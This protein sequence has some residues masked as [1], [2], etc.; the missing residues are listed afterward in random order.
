[1]T[2]LLD[3]MELPVHI[4]NF[5]VVGIGASAGGL[6]AFKQLV[7]AIPE[8]SGMAYVFVQHVGDTGESV[9]PELL[10]KESKIPIHTITDKI[11]L[12]PDNIYITPENKEVTA[13]GSGTLVLT[14]SQ[15][16]NG[17]N[18]PIDRFFKSLADVHQSF[19]VGVV[20]S[21]NALDGTDGLKAIIENGGVTVAQNPGTA[22]FT[23]MPL[24]AIN[25]E[26]V[27]FILPAEKIPG[28][29]VKIK[30]SYMV[31][32]AGEKE[33]VPREDEAIYKNI[34]SLLLKRTGH[35]FSNYKQ[36][37]MR[38]RIARRMA[39]T[40]KNE[41]A[42]YLNFIKHNK[43]EQHALFNDL[44]IPVTHFFRD[45][46]TYRELIAGI[47]PLILK[48]KNPLD[49]IRVWVAGCATG[50]EAYS[51]AICLHE[52][53]ESRLPGSK[54]QIFASDISEHV[55]EKARN[56]IYSKQAVKEISHSR[57]SRYFVKNGNDY[58]VGKTI[59]EMCVFAVHNFLRNPPFSRM[60]MVSCRN[61]FIYMDT[62]FQKKALSVFHYALNADGILLLG[63]AE[64]TGAAPDLFT[65]MS[66][67]H[68][69][70]TRKNVSTGLLGISATREEKE[71]VPSNDLIVK[72]D[73]KDEPLKMAEKV[74][75]PKYTPPA[76]IVN[77]QMEI[78]HFLG[79]L[80]LILMPQQGK[81]SL[82]ILK[83]V[84]PEFVFELRKILQCAKKETSIVRSEKIMYM[85][86]EEQ[87]AFSVEIIPLQ[88]TADVH[89]LVIFNRAGID[90]PAERK[91]PPKTN[92]TTSETTAQLRIQK[93]ENELNQMRED[94]RAISDDQEIFSEELK[95]ANEELLSS[96]EELQSINEELET[97]KEELEAGNE[98][99]LVLN[100][101]LSEQHEQLLSART[102]AQAIVSSINEPIIILDR[103]F[104]IKNANAFFY[105]FFQ[106]NETSVEGKSF[107]DL[108]FGEWNNPELRA[109]LENVIAEKK[110]LKNYEMTVPISSHEQRVLLLS[111][112]QLINEPSGELLILLIFRDITDTR[113]AAQLR[114][115]EER[116]R[117]ASELT[118]LGTWELNLSTKRMV[119]S[120]KINEIMGVESSE[121]TM[122][123][124]LQAVHPQDIDRAREAFDSAVAKRH[125][126]FE[127][128]II[129]NNGTQRWIR[130]NGNLLPEQR[131][132]SSRLLGTVMDITDQ[133]KYLTELQE[134]ERLFK[135]IADAAPVLI[136][137]AG[138]DKRFYFFNKGWLDFTGKTIGQESGNGWMRGVHEEDREAITEN[139]DYSFQN[140]KEFFMEFRLKRQDGK[141]RWISMH[142]I[143]RLS[144]GQVFEGYIGGGVDITD[145]K[146]FAIT[147]SNQVQQRTKE[148]Q[149]SHELLK[150]KNKE[151]ERS[152]S[153]LAS[154]SYVASHDLQEPLRKIQTFSQR[155]LGNEKDNLSAVSRDYF[156]RMN[157]AA[158]E[159]QQLMDDIL[160]YSKVSYAPNKAEL[161]SLNTIMDNVISGLNNM[162]EEKN[163][164]IEVGALP[165]LKVIQIQ[166][167]QLFTN[168]VVNALKYSRQ[169]VNPRVK[170]NAAIVSSSEIAMAENK[171]DKNYW[172]IS[173]AD[174]GIGFE[175]IYGQR[176]FEMFQRLHA[177]TEYKGTGMGLAICKKI[178]ESYNGYIDATG[179]PGVGATFNIYLPE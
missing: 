162:L 175:Q 29:L 57:L 132:Y 90:A 152:N 9:L 91:I 161:V 68:K 41:L 24:S 144:A 50:E 1:M 169:G 7:S 118:G 147:L 155:I 138:S 21:G 37:T 23:N 62:V 100:R 46:K 48:N 61:V 177:K 172:K 123:E 171:K 92:K 117:L 17:S 176:I 137:L 74:L 77:A 142:G 60:D 106:T 165:T 156:T 157:N 11:T 113:M 163:A 83:M 8:N 112:R 32:H 108:A 49:P 19:A 63:K 40:E 146:N 14:P 143:P 159:M 104:F 81:P 6:N 127:V 79:N 158:K 43:D 178:V 141:Y 167:I 59:R 36:P 119:N 78:I 82:H 101:E 27:D 160:N 80:S 4:Q 110:E 173:V 140:R 75:F 42:E 73:T 47:F 87:Y 31:N 45:P 67:E 55:I 33:I 114:E 102:Y 130:V 151:L 116:F 139:I 170:I 35:D 149:Q 26:V 150:E 70:Y 89:Y 51:V 22:E 56:G 98:E 25:A 34:L 54:I 2:T 66:R 76:V 136:W 39:A 124:F 65:V 168:L 129:G 99:L 128:R 153:E 95:S 94:F 120:I 103:Y 174:N 86:N 12:A 126:F 84:R 133:K 145:Q 13:T 179:E 28:Q 15:E 125:L 85:L 16:M 71:I 96:S 72:P 58:Q 131:N 69:I 97:S 164:I 134:S 5:P 88:N 111:G 3:R 154:F 107:F 121:C 166:F 64:S 93:L 105:S 115:S 38:R 10:S 30:E 20:L 109:L 52:F 53:F 148:L 135:A 122:D 44:L 18:L